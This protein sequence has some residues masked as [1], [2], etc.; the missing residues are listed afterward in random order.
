[1]N[2]IKKKEDE[3]IKKEKVIKEKETDIEK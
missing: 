2:G 3:L 1:M